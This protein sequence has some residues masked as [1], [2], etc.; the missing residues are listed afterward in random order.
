[1]PR[2]TSGYLFSRDERT[3]AALVLDLLRARGLTLATAESCTGGLVAAR[4]TGVPGASDVFLGAVV[5]YSNEVKAAQLGVPGRR[6]GSARRRLRRGGRG[7]GPR[8]A[9]A[10]RSGRRGR[11]D[12][13][14]RAGRWNGGEAGRARVPACRQGRRASSRAASTSRETGRRS[15][16]ARRWRRCISCGELSH[17]RDRH[18]TTPRLAWPAM[19]DPALLRAPAAARGRRR[20]VAWQFEHLS[21]RS[22]R[23]SSAGQARPAREPACHARLP[24]LTAR[25][26]G[27]GDRRCARRGRPRGEPRQ[28][29]GPTATARRGASG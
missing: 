29:C 16:S 22:W 24:R 9:R 21:R 2:R 1:M 25:A 23:T 13:R 3:T 17:S 6:A 4:L 20:V 10:A 11:G 15:A 18:G 28:S 19:N 14:R 27:A 8:R 26:R 5:A 7:D 12:G